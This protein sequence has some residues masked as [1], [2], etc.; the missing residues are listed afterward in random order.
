MSSQERGLGKCRHLY[1]VQYPHPNQKKGKDCV[2]FVFLIE[3]I[4]QKGSTISLF[5]VIKKKKFKILLAKGK[6]PVFKEAF[7][8]VVKYNG[9]NIL[10]SV[11]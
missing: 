3:A 5:N 2:L 11:C 8:F 4:I 10:S 9:M 6:Q 7:S 1:L